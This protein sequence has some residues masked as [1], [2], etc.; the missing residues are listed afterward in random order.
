VRSVWQSLCGGQHL[1]NLHHHGRARDDLLALAAG[2]SP[3]LILD[4]CCAAGAMLRLAKEIFPDA[5]TAGAEGDPR[6]QAEAGSAC[7]EFFALPLESFI[8]APPEPLL[9]RV[10]L[11]ILNDVLEH[12]VDPFRCLQRL[13]PLLS[14]RGCVLASLPNIQNA[15]LI[16]ELASGRFPYAEAGILDISHLRFFT[17]G[18]AVAMF[19]EAGFAV[20]AERRVA[21]PRA[22]RLL[23]DLEGGVVTTPH[24]SIRDVDAA[25]RRNLETL[26][27]LFLLDHGEGARTAAQPTD[28]I[29]PVGPALPD[30]EKADAQKRFYHVWA[31]QR[32]LAPAARAR[33]E[34]TV[35]AMK[36]PER[37]HLAA[38]VTG[39]QATVLR[40]TCYSLEAQLYPHWRFSVVSFEPAPA[41]W[42]DHP[43]C[44]WHLLGDDDDSLEI[45]G[46]LLAEGDAA[47]VGEV[48]PGDR[49]PPDALFKFAD[50]ALRHPD[51]CWIYS[52]ED[53]FTAAQER[54][55][56]LFKP[57]F[58]PDLLRSLH[59][60][61]GLS[62]V[63]RERFVAAGAFD[64]GFDGVEDYALSLRLA[65][66]LEP[67]RIGHIAEVLYHRHESGRVSCLDESAL[68]DLG[69]EALRAHLDVLGWP[70]DVERGPVPQTWRV[71]YRLL[72]TPSVA[73]LVPTKNRLD[74]LRECVDSVLA[75]TDYPHY[76]IVIIDN[77]SSEPEALDY[78]GSLVAAGKA[79]VLRYDAPFNFSA[80]NNMAVAAVE[81]DYVLL[82]NNDTK[83]LDADWLRRMLSFAE[84]A[85]AGVV[86]PMLLFEDGRVQHAGV[87]L[88]LGNM[89][90]EHVFIGRDPDEAVLLERLRVTQNY[91]VVTGACMLVRRADY[92]AVG[93][94]DAEN[95]PRQFQDVDFCLK[96]GAHLGKRI[97]W[98]SDI[99]L[100]HKGSVSFSSGA[101]KKVADS[102]LPADDS[103][104]LCSSGADIPDTAGGAE[105]AAA[106]GLAVAESPEVEFMYRQWRDAIANDPYYNRNLA[107]ADRS[108]GIETEALLGSSAWRTLPFVVASPA[109]RTG[110]GEYRIMAPMRALLDA[111]KVEGGQTVRIFGPTEIMRLGP[112]V[113]VCQRQTELHQLA[114]L[115]RYKRRTSTFLVY[116]L[117]DLVTVG[118]S[119]RTTEEQRKQREKYVRIGLESVDRLVA[120]TTRI[121]DEYSDWCRETIIVPNYLPLDRWGAVTA[122][123]LGRP[124]PRVGWAGGSSHAADLEMIADVVKILQHEVEWVF[125][126]MCP[127][128]LRPFVHEFHEGIAIEGYPARLAS[129]NLDLALAPLVDNDFNRSRTALRILEYGILG[130]PVVASDL[131]SYRAGYPVSLVGAC[132]DD[133][134]S[135]I[136]SMIADR[137]ALARAGDALREHVRANWLLDRNTDVWMR[138]WL[139]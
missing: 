26:E 42:R 31:L 134:V 56:P 66:L 109:D 51:W 50:A 126:G 76:R 47:W 105:A 88:G 81:A 64:P 100:V 17:L 7:D 103:R 16:D 3:A 99:C 85:G 104:G 90:A 25:T 30:D 5:R 57:D 29:A 28:D 2:E 118:W 12:L 87:V 49:F 94:L 1:R 60:I 8:E 11:L 120:S 82:L 18:D 95:L 48:F 21:D 97:V 102:R 74:D 132:V 53:R 139:P 78:M 83:V 27:F 33:I 91:A 37:V 38:F 41:W 35:A 138:A 68:W 113:M 73:I 135:A 45:L 107:L 10:D 108:A 71:R 39:Q 32:T 58:S 110:C 6:L 137:D 77:Q 133:W 63:R 101:E 65:T 98:S 55:D 112:D 111:G 40:E 136:R 125:F 117:D 44:T 129:L 121:A 75:L 128:A 67:F 116:D 14:G 69:G 119:N 96:I 52:D 114:A 34:A 86:G 19:R 92:L 43:K 54:V 22:K 123:R 9:G 72:S 15:S 131:P 70:A 59:Y 13:R 124:R 46:R 4:P 115:K 36:A 23:R 62:L 84:V 130:Y 106:E 122:R 127:E 89:P 61:G 20:R 80:M 79:S 24:L 93:G